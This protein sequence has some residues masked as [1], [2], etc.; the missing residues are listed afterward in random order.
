MRRVEKPWGH[1]II[2]SDT[3]LYVGKILVVRAG[4]RLSLQYHLAKDES[5]LIDEGQVELEL[6]DDEGVLQ[7]RMMNVGD[8]VRILPG[9]R[10]RLRAVTDCRVIEVSTPHLDDVVRV[11]D[12]FGRV[13]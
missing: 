6:D 8:A 10:H 1:E 13:Q 3:E 5:F 4:F 7:P 2:W 9:R 11:S 12:D